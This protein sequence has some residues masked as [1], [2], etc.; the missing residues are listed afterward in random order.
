MTVGLELVQWALWWMAEQRRRY[1]L[2]MR[3]TMY[4]MHR[5][6]NVVRLRLGLPVKLL[7][8]ASR[9]AIYLTHPR[10]EYNLVSSDL[11]WVT[12]IEQ[13]LHNITKLGPGY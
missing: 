5:R 3:K 6:I 8:G 1:I 2:N 7:P 12:Q 11:N 10:D 4:Y 9:T 13:P